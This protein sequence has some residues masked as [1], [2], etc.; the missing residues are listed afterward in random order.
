MK[1]LKTRNEFLRDQ[2]EIFKKTSSGFRTASGRWAGGENIYSVVFGKQNK[3][4]GESNR[5]WSSNGKWS[6]NDAEFKCILRNSNFIFT[7]IAGVPT[8]TKKNRDISKIE[9]CV[10]AE[11]GRGF[12]LKTI[13]GYIQYNTHAK[14]PEL[15]VKKRATA[16]KII[17]AARVLK[18][19]NDEKLHSTMVTINDSV[20][21]G[22]CE[23]GTT[24]F[25]NEKILPVL[26]KKGFFV[27]KLKALRADF[28]LSICDD[29]F[30]NRAISKALLK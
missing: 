28:L 19:R 22:N 29:N 27:K 30:T 13:I 21:A 7:Q 15:V 24:N 6:G 20:K 26:A 5:V 8:I 3:F 23:I 1:T 9:P 25:I 12:T 14:T 16:L 4:Y 17:L 10:W 11:Q 2:T 18:N